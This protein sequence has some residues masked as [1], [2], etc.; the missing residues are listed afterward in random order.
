MATVQKQGRGYKITV[1]QG[2][3]YNGKRISQYMTW[4]PEPGMTDRQIK[5]ELERQAVLFEEKVLSSTVMNANIRLADFAE[6]FMTEYGRIYLKP[7]TV[8]SYEDNLRRIN[9]AL[10]HIK[11][12]DLR[13]GHI[14]TF[15][16][17]LQESGIRNRITAVCKVD[18]QQQIGTKRGDLTAFAKKAVVSR[19]TVKQAVDGLTISGESAD[20]IAKALGMKTT[21]TFNITT[22]TDPLAPASIM[23][24]HHTLSSI[25]AKA[26]LKQ[27]GRCR[28]KAKF[29]P[30]RSGLSRRNGCSTII[31]VVTC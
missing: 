9:Q 28:R 27:P 15:Y 5:K 31:R 8:H 14:N 2:Y 17:N 19:T 29:R 6:K 23:S 1:S 26:I 13:T 7:K 20:A 12:N 21:K 16:Q 24:Y 11:L 4:V 22:H 10:G 18:L 25:L 3:D 30:P